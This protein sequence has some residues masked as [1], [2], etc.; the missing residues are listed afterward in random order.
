MR[1]LSLI[2][3]V[4]CTV[5]LLAADPFQNAYAKTPSSGKKADSSAMDGKTPVNVDNFVRAE[6]DHMFCA[7]MKAFNAKIGQLILLRKPTTPDNQPVIRMNQETLYTGVKYL[8]IIEGWNY[9]IRMYEPR[10]EILDGFW[11]FPAIK[12]V[13]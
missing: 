8:P 6:S 2:R 5:A 13:K 10:K 11:Q 3:T 7:N 9:A 4:T 1:N 12:P